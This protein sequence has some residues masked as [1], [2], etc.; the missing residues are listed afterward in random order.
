MCTTIIQICVHSS[1]HFDSV[2]CCVQVILCFLSLPIKLLYS[3]WSPKCMRVSVCFRYKYQIFRCVSHMPSLQYCTWVCQSH[4]VNVISTCMQVY[5]L[6]SVSVNTAR[7][8]FCSTWKP[9]CLFMLSKLKCASPY[10]P[11]CA[12]LCI[13]DIEGGRKQKTKDG[14]EREGAWASELSSKS[15][16]LSE[17]PTPVTGAELRRRWWESFVHIKVDLEKFSSPHIRICS[18]LSCR[19]IFRDASLSDFL[20]ACAP[21]CWWPLVPERY[22]ILIVSI[23]SRVDASPSIVSLPRHLWSVNIDDGPSPR[24][25]IQ[26]FFSTWMFNR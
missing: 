20:L 10:S 17:R 11:S 22:A 24:F 2:L 26:L 6:Y 4:R 3:M 1:L 21:E 12:L 19:S 25:H 13:T 9:H 15:D 5:W 18:M 16:R 23:Y 7:G 8:N 14:H